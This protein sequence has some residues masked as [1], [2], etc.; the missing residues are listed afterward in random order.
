[1]VQPL[2]NLLQTYSHGYA[3]CQLTNL[4]KPNLCLDAEVLV[5]C[6]CSVDLI[7][8]SNEIEK[9]QLQKETGGISA[10]GFDNRITILP[11]YQ[12][13]KITVNLKHPITGHITTKTAII[14]VFER[15]SVCTSEIGI[16]CSRNVLSDE[17][18][19]SKTTSHLFSPHR[20]SEMTTSTMSIDDD[21]ESNVAILKLSPLKHPLKDGDQYGILGYPAMTKLNIGIYFGGNYIFGVE[22][23]FEH[24]SPILASKTQV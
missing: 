10:R 17:A 15:L 9:L 12:D 11:K 8:P 16:Q 24:I 14:S 7:L 22:R 23:L 19:I 18:Q 20:S 4:Y 1:A 13:V 6:G 21:A 3:P 5:D 2:I